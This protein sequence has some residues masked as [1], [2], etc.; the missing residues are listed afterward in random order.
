MQNVISTTTNAKARATLEGKYAKLV[1]AKFVL[2]CAL[3]VDVLAEAKNFSL[4]TQKIDISIID[5]VEAVEN[6][7]QNYQRLLK[8]VEKDPAS[9][10]KLPALKLIIDHVEANEDG[11]PCYQ[12]VKVKYFLREKCY[13]VNHEVEIVKA[14]VECF[15]KRYGNT[16]SETSEQLMF[17]QMKRI[18]SYL[19]S[20]KFSTTMFGLIQ[21]RWPNTLPSLQPSK[22]FSIATKKWPFLI[23]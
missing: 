17:M 4:Q 7:K 10:L 23:V 5:V 3:F 11:E 13:I 22:G 1:D 8:P 16:I 2:H 6:T 18:V 19:M 14:I 21:R 15:D 20:V 9:I 12:D